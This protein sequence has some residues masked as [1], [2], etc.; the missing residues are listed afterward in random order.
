[1]TGKGVTIGIDLGTTYCCVGYYNANGEVRILT[2]DQGGRTTP[3]Y[4][5]YM[6]DERLV[7]EPSKNVSLENIENTVFDA[8]RFIGRK[9]SDPDVQEDLRNVSYAVVNKG[10]H[11]MIKVNYLKK[12][13]YFRPEEVS[14]VLLS[15]LKDM[16]ERAIGEPVDGAVITVP[17]YFNDSQRQATKHAGEIAGLKVLRIINEPTAAAV[18]YGLDRERTNVLVFDL[19]G[20]TFDVSLLN[21]DDGV[22]KVLATAG[23]THL[24]GE[25]FDTIVTDHVISEYQ[26]KT[27]VNLKKDLRASRLVKTCVEQAKR[28]LSS[29]KQTSIC[30]SQ[31]GKPFMYKLSRAKFDS[32]CMS[33]FRRCLEPVKKALRDANMQPSEVND[34][35][36]VGGSSRIPKVQSMLKEFFGGR[37][38]NMTV[39][40]DEV[41]AHGAAIQAAALSGQNKDLDILLIDVAP[42]TLGVETLKG[43][44]DTI[45]KRQETIPCEHTKTYF[46]S[47][48]NQTSVLI[49]V[50]E[51]E[52]AMT[53]DNNHLGEF[54]LSGIPPMPRA[55]GEVDVTFKLDKNGILSV[56]AAEKST[57]STRTITI[58][59][60]KG[61]LTKE[62]LDAKIQEAETYR[63]QDEEKRNK[64]KEINETEEYLYAVRDSEDKVRG[65]T[66]ADIETLEEICMEG[67][68]WLEDKADD[69]DSDAIREQRQQWEQRVMTV[70]NR[71]N[72]A[73]GQ[74]VPDLEQLS[75]Q[76]NLDQVIRPDDGPVVEDIEDD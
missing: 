55:K 37:E 75:S 34:I 1:M 5:T 23:D 44:M 28:V 62:E 8:K 36:L 42:L 33:A 24:G 7:G 61:R 25:D 76:F 64:I 11:P 31:L 73:A 14:A 48:A 57:G 56:T 51:G 16:A 46:T 70:Y 32:L 19:G 54:E 40:P 13:H 20:G 2:N 26:K 53:A 15:Y 35:V 39:N 68:S 69:A 74:Y 66:E 63:Q 67:F 29:A 58:T 65:L 18:A 3:S 22:F 21:I 71:A 4:V 45:I 10:D 47:K 59:N 43:A 49:K 27:G 12:N 41:V 30:L 6:D 52:R 17:A 60:N 38:L 50:Y 9:Y 72:S